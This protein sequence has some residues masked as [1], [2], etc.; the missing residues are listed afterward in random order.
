LHG[1]GVGFTP[2]L[3]SNTPAVPSYG[4]VGF[5]VLPNGYAAGFVYSTPLLAGLQLNLGLYDPTV[6]A[7]KLP[8]TKAPRPEFELTADEPLG[9]T[10][11]L[12]LYVNGTRQTI[13]QAGATDEITQAPQGLGFGGRVELGPVRLA[14]GGHVGKGIGFGYFGNTDSSVMNDNGD[15]RPTNGFYG[16][17]QVALGKIDLSAGYGISRAT[18]LEADRQSNPDPM[19]PVNPATG[20]ADPAFSW[21]TSQSAISAAVVVHAADWLHFD[22]DAM[23]ASFKWNLGEEQKVNLFNAGTTLTW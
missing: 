16:M 12:H 8:R 7:G 9:S 23:F 1:Y 13:Y 6:F 3:V 17:G 4:Q 22:L 11:K 18:V 15:L 14:G 5:G 20:Q 10:G 19:A 21:I 2:D